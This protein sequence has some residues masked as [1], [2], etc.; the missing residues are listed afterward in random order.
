MQTNPLGERPH[1]FKLPTTT[2][3]AYTFLNQPS[4]YVSATTSYLWQF[5]LWAWA[6]YTDTHKVAMS[7]K[8]IPPK[9]IRPHEKAWVL[10]AFPTCTQHIYSLQSHYRCIQ[11][12]VSP[13]PSPLTTSSFSESPPSDDI[14]CQVC[15]SPFDK[16]QMLL[17][18]M[19]NTGCILTAFSHP[20]PL[21]HMDSGNAP[22]APRAT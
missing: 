14:H 10:L 16:H 12:S 2:C 17:C 8:A 19:C 18:D 13:V 5:N 11:P 22:Y 4:F 9:L 6:T 1:T 20:L 21:S 15:Q 7:L 3:K